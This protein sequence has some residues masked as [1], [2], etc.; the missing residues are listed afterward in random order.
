MDSKRLRIL[1]TLS[2]Q[3]GQVTVANGYRTDCRAV[4]RGRTHIGKDNPLPCI[5]LLEAPTPDE[6][7]FRANAGVRQKDDWYLFVQGFVKDDPV[8]PTDP[9]HDFLAD[10]K[11][12][13]SENFNA[14]SSEYQI[15]GLAASFRMEPGTCA[16]PGEISPTAYFWLRLEVGVAEDL[17]EP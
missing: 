13:L 2:E 16:P 11:K 10:V 17:R 1:K 6:E 7:P 5:T 8:N 4:Y 15:R 14:D 3:L 12:C 9:A